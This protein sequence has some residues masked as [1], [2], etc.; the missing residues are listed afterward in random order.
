MKTKAHVLLI[1]Y[2]KLSRKRLINYL[3]RNKIRLSI[4]S[5]SYKGNINS[6]VEQF[7]NYDNAL[8]F[9]K[10]NIVYISLPNSLHYT[11]AKK[12]LN[13][14]YH[15][16]VDKPICENYS[17]S[18]D[19]VSLAKKKNRLISEATFFNY[20]NQI[21]KSLMIIKNKKIL[22]INV[23]FIIPLPP[24]NSIL[25]SRRLLGGVIMD[26]APYAAAIHRIFLNKKII[27]KRITIKKNKNKLPVE[28]NLKLLCENITYQGKFKFGGK[29][30]NQIEIFYGDHKLK[31]NR[32]FSPPENDDLMLEIHK[33]K[34]IQKLMIKKDNC[35]RN[36]FNKILNSINKKGYLNFY[37]TILIDQKFR[38][39]IY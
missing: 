25:L 19:L 30:K 36:Y 15:V 10:A 5:K 14:G 31:I 9:S 27:K 17:K 32:A 7:N 22:K 37:N 29:Y 24:K 35:F 38:D 1:G 13:Y 20:H 28:M 4:A 11:W 6:I 3:I 8:K 26:M 23:N 12:A 34:S 39:N 2:S 33:N 21:K 18:L 16:I